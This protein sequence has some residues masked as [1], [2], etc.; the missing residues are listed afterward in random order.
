MGLRQ[1]VAGSRRAKGKG[2][3][4]LCFKKLDHQRKRRRRGRC[5][6]ASRR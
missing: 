6:Q 3:M 5:R 1:P 4:R 2:F